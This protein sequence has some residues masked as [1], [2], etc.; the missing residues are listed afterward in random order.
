MGK[1]YEIEH[2]DIS[3]AAFNT[4]NICGVQPGPTCQFHL[5]ETQEFPAGTDRFS[6]E[7]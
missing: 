2:A 1:P 6:Q 4:A 7:L 3:L 5:R